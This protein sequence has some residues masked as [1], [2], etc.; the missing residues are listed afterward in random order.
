MSLVSYPSLAEP[1][2]PISEV[3]LSCAAVTITKKPPV[4]QCLIPTKINFFIIWTP[5]PF[6]TFQRRIFSALVQHSRLLPADGTSVSAGCGELV[7][8]SF[9]PGMTSIPC[10]HIIL[11]KASHMATLNLGTGQRLLISWKSRASRLQWIKVIIHLLLIGW[12]MLEII[13]AKCLCHIW[14]I[15]NAQ[16]MVMIISSLSW[17]PGAAPLRDLFLRAIYWIWWWSKC[18]RTA[19]MV[20]RK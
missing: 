11:D 5:Q 7:T 15:I 18:N 12:Q 2:F 19:Y 13:C 9:L 14:H 17:I 20:G 4:S 8:M 3:S 6:T 1:Q 10:S 16:W